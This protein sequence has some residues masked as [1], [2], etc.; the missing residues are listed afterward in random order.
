MRTPFFLSDPHFGHSKITDGTF[1]PR[2][3]FKDADEM[4]QAICDNWNSVVKDGDK[5]YVLGDVAISKKKIPII[6]S[7]KGRKTLILGNHDIFRIKEYAPYF[8][9]IRSIRVFDR[10]IATHIPIHPGSLGRFGFNVHGHTHFNDVEDKRYINVC[11]EK[12]DYF[13]VSLEWILSEIKHRESNE[14]Q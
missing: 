13:P 7:L 3:P 11:V 2:R 1:N 6:K 8:D 12:T 5:V 9:N 10:F 14:Y 4:D